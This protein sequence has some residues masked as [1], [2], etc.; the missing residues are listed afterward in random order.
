MQGL[1]DWSYFWMKKQPV[2]EKE[3]QMIPPARESLMYS[4][5]VCLS[6]A[7]TE[8]RRFLKGD[9]SGCRLIAQSGSHTGGVEAERLPWPYFR[10]H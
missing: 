9:V 2:R 6:R 4:S 5:M 3:G 1:R 8:Y 10:P 7:D